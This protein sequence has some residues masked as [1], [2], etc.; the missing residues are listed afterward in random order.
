MA[1]YLSYLHIVVCGDLEAIWGFVLGLA[2]MLCE[3]QSTKDRQISNSQ[4]S[5]GIM[6]NFL[7]LSFFVSVNFRTL[8]WEQTGTSAVQM[9]RKGKGRSRSYDRD[10][11]ARTPY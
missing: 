9:T 7:S 1:S 11:D 8:P 5:D 10:D 2:A 6:K 3:F 4:I